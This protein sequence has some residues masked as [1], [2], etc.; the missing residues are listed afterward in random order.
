[1]HDL[2]AG[3]RGAAEEAAWLRTARLLPRLADNYKRDAR[4]AEEEAE[5][6]RQGIAT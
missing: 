5:A 2:V 1:M 3:Y 6:L 4:S